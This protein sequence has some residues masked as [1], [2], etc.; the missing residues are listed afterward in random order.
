MCW[1]LVVLG[2]QLISASR[3][4]GCAFLGQPDGREIGSRVAAAPGKLGL[5]QSDPS[6]CLLSEF[7][8]QESSFA[9]RY[10]RGFKPRVK[11]HGFIR[12]GA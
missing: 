5:E 12:A 10:F 2:L 9:H 3:L 11:G 7:L 1:P 6:A 4:A 8:I